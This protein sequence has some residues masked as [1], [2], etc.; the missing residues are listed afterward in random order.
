MDPQSL[1]IDAREM[2][3]L[4]DVSMRQVYRLN[5]SGQLPAPLALGGCKRWLRSE[6]EAWL[7]AGAPRR[8]DWEALRNSACA[9][10]R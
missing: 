2:A 5:D 4:L 8:K 10:L 1:C 6:V 3:R 7:A 9:P